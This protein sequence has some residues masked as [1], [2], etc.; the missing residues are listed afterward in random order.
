MAEITNSQ[1]AP[2]VP[3][4]PT[5]QTQ[6]QPAQPV[7]QLAQMNQAAQ[8]TAKPG[9]QPAQQTSNDFMTYASNSKV[10]ASFNPEMGRLT[11]NGIPVNLKQ[12]GLTYENGQLVGTQD[13]YDALLSPFVNVDTKAVDVYRDMEEY[14]AYETPEE[15]RNMMLQ[16]IA[17]SNQKYQYQFDEDPMVEEAREE[18]TRSISGLAAQYGFMYSGETA[19]IIEAQLKSLTPEFEQAAYNRYKADIDMQFNFLGTIMKW[20]QMQYDRSQNGINLLQVKSN[21]VMALAEREYRSFKLML[22]QHRNEQQI[23]LSQEQFNLEKLKTET[24]NAFNTIDQLGFVNN[25]AAAILGIP[26]GTKARWV[27]QLRAEHQNK[28]DIMV[29]E[30]KYNMDMAK[31]QAGLEKDIL[32][33]KEEL[34]VASKLKLMEQDYTY[35]SNLMDLKYKHQ[36]ELD[37]IAA[38]EKAREKAARD[39]EKAKEQELKDRYEAQFINVDYSVWKKQ[40]TSQFVD[41]NGNLKK[42]MEQQAA[43]WIKSQL[44]RGIKPDMVDKLINTYNIPEYNSNYYEVEKKPYEEV[45]KEMP[46]VFKAKQKG[47]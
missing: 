47:R 2:T 22:D 34:S 10:N 31:Y 4:A 44:N 39:A 38:A 24:E 5:G 23:K 37:A 29:K 21:F 16:V 25:E 27:Q 33:Y 7:T 13:S 41:K 28:I 12:S 3:L 6:V 17:R 35:Q 30:N 36:K 42:G 1:T 19:N 20:D 8:Q 26:V 14:Q 15:Y 18:L 40:F 43:R 46:N 11:I 9:M 45:I 32:S